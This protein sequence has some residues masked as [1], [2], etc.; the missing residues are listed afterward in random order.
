ML[1]VRIVAALVAAYAL[2]GIPFALI[3]SRRHGIDI[4]EHGSGNTGATNVLRV[5]GTRAGVTVLILDLLKGTAAVGLA[6]LLHPLV[7]GHDA[8]DWVML[9]AAML[10]VI[11]HTFSPYMGFR[12][13]K[14]VATAAGTLLPI[15]PS[16]WFILLLLFVLVVYI[17]RMVSLGSV[18]IAL[19]FPM[20]CLLLYSDRPALV[21]FSLFAATL[22]IW[23]HRTNIVRIIRG[24]EAKIGEGQSDNEDSEASNEQHTR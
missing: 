7:L 22:V 5:L 4:R 9:G 19:L 12:G 15:A 18:F 20:L 13:G 16:A 6:S 2:G 24:E 3:I 10:A 17:S 14:G 21:W 11:G 1:T 23:R 8:H